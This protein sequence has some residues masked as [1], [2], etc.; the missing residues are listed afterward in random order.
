MLQRKG[1]ALA[2]QSRSLSLPPGLIWMMFPVAWFHP[3]EHTHWANGEALGPDVCLCALL[4][5]FKR[6][7]KLYKLLTCLFVCLCMQKEISTGAWPRFVFFLGHCQYRIINIWV[8]SC[9]VFV[10][11]KSRFNS[12]LGHKL[13]SSKVCSIRFFN[14]DT[15]IFGMK[16]QYVDILSQCSIFS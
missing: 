15:V 13:I 2:L 8:G 1:E 16:P 14:T 9:S 3:S 4:T 11:F 10:K 7:Y 12:F 5:G 6:F